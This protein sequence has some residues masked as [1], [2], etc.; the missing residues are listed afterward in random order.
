LRA[1][2]RIRAALPKAHLLLVGDGPDEEKLRR[3]VDEMSL[4]GS[5]IFVPSLYKEGLPNVILESMA[6]GV[7]V[8]SSRL[9]GIPEAVKD[10]E[11]GIL[12]SPG[13]VRG[14]ASAI[15]GLWRDRDTYAQ[16]RDRALY[17]IRSVFDCKSKLE[18]YLRFLERMQIGKN[19]PMEGVTET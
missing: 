3:A 14:L 11:T 13:D 9:A 5:V 12:V 15:V 6:M 8:V 4:G 1:L 16:M 7:P 18:Q 10:G 17:L 2:A 19:V